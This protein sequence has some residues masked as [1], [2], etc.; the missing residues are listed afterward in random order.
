MAFKFHLH[1]CEERALLARRLFFWRDN[2]K[3]LIMAGKLFWP[4]PFVPS[5]VLFSDASFTGCA[6]FIQDS[7]LVFAEIGPLKSLVSLPF[8]GSW[9]GFSLLFSSSRII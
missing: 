4:V 8:R 3:C 1:F 2:L 6:A 9:L 5:K 7:S